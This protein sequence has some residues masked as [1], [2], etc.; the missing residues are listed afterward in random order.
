MD[1]ETHQGSPEENEVR[2]VLTGPEMDFEWDDSKSQLREATEEDMATLLREEALAA[3]LRPPEKV[4]SCQ[5][6]EL[7]GDCVARRSGVTVG[8]GGVSNV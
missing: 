3:N 5:G 7:V 4:A 8:L 1:E 2:R 6:T